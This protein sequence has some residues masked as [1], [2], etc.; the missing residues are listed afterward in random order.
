MLLLASG[1]AAAGGV[2]WGFGILG[3]RL[4]VHRS[5]NGQKQVRAALT[6][7]VYV[8]TTCAAPLVDFAAT[9]RAL[10]ADTLGDPRWRRRVP[11]IVGCGVVSGLGGLL[12]TVAFAWSAGVNSALISMVENGTYTVSGAVLIAAFFGER[13]APAGYLAAALIVGG[14]LLAQTTSSHRPAGVKQA[15]ADLACAPSFSD[16]DAGSSEEGGSS[17]EHGMVDSGEDART[18]RRGAT[19]REDDSSAESS[20]V[21]PAASRRRVV[22]VAVAAG[23]CWGCGPLGKKWGV[24]GAPESHRHV[25]TTCTYLLYIST[26]T[27]V[28]LARL[29]CA[30]AASRSAA[31]GDPK[32]LCLLAGTVCCGLLSGLGGL[33]STLAFAESQGHGAIVS[34]VE[35]GVYTVAGAL[36]ITV[37]FRERL[38]RRQALAAG[39][40]VAGLLI[41]AAR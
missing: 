5:P 34:V 15:E 1:L 37:L 29:L 21:A 17:S 16:S 12:G 38:T 3:K 22:L 35:N 9:D 13:P 40:V 39:L 14:I 7:F 26:T 8:L 32:F 20:A 36:M 25:W 10:L 33:V 6:I 4:G 2:L 19:C 18:G 28:P 24:D 30:D 41:S 27:V 23:A 31:I 11:V